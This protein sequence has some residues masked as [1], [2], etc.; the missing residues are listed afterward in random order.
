MKNCPHCKKTIDSNSD[1]CPNCGRVLIERFNSTPKSK[2][3]TNVTRSI[4]KSLITQINHIIKKISIFRLALWSNFKKIAPYI[5]IIAIVLFAIYQKGGNNV[6]VSVIPKNEK[7]YIEPTLAPVIPT[8]EPKDYISLSNGKIFYRDTNNFWGDGEL[9]INNGSDSDAILKLVNIATNKSVL[10]V[11]I[12]AKSVYDIAKISDGN[13]K[14]LFNLGNDWN[15]QLKAFNQNSSYEVFE[16]NLDFITTNTKYSTFSITLNPVVGGDA[17]T[18]DV[19]A[20]DF[21]T[22]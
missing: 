5:V 21:G 2:P 1:V 13:Y 10:T 12:K 20:E 16:E 14:V 7:N 19:K 3:I 11:Y 8:K 22:Y 9:R 6:P 4:K 17:R 18:N 15:D